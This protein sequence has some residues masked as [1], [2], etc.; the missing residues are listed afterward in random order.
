MSENSGPTPDSPR[1]RLARAM[2]ESGITQ[3][4]IGRRTNVGPQY[5]NDVLH[6]RRP[7]TEAFAEYLQ[8][9][10][11]FDKMWLKYGEGQVFRH[12]PPLAGAPAASVALTSLPL[13]DRP[14]RG[15]PLDSDRWVG[16][17]HS[18]PRSL[19]RPDAVRG[20]RY[21]LK[22]EDCG[23]K[24]EIRDGDL[25]LVENV[26]KPSV[27][28]LTGRWCIVSISGKTTFRKIKITSSDRTRGDVWGWCVGILWRALAAAD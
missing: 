1:A 27:E 9:E 4:E 8:T 6:N 26:L 12:L 20:F 17:T 14:C 16:S 21:V 18:V 3:A 13:L 28:E 24:G 5:V 11:G 7:L 10:F 19:A 25:L 15:N 23:R 22:V 2:K